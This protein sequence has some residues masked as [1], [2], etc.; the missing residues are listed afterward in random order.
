MEK[1]YD[2]LTNVWLPEM[3]LA[4]FAMFAMNSMWYALLMRK[5]YEVLRGRYLAAPATPP[6]ASV[7]IRSFLG[8]SVVCYLIALADAHANGHPV[9]I[10]VS[11]AV[12]WLFISLDMMQ[13]IFWEKMPLAMFAIHSGATFLGFAAAGT[14]FW[15]V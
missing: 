8:Y 14:V 13:A 10:F 7:F 6:N 4:A 9:A 12:V 2:T 5:P 1:Y 11:L 3:L 15:L